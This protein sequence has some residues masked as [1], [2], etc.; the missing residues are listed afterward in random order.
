MFPFA[1]QE[2]A[3]RIHDKTY[4]ILHAA[5][6]EELFSRLLSLPDDHPDVKDERIPYW[7]EVWP[8]A[9][10]MAEFIVQRPELFL[11][12]SVLEI[13]CGLGLPGIVAGETASSVVLTDYLPEAIRLAEHNW[14]LNHTSKATTSLLDWRTADASYAAQ[15]VLASDVAYER[16]MFDPLLAAFQQLTLPGGTI[17]VSEPDRHFARDFFKALPEAQWHV[18][19]HPKKVTRK[20]ITS[21]VNIHVLTGTGE[22][23]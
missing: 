3:F 19:T 7:A 8:S 10:A 4:R 5:D 13:G 6:V 20:L 2:E 18:E 9:I 1:V 14:Q 11:G 17:I 23:K 15:V 16:R 21:H 22:K 12:K